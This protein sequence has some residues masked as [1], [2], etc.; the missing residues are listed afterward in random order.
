MGSEE[1]NIFKPLPHGSRIAILFKF[2]I[3]LLKSA[4]SIMGGTGKSALNVSK[5]FTLQEVFR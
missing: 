3:L 2:F 4:Y 1:R 5:E